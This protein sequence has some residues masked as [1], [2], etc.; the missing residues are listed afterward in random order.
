VGLQEIAREYRMGTPGREPPGYW[1]SGISP[2]RKLALG[3]VLF[4]R[5]LTIHT[6]PAITGYGKPRRPE[7]LDFCQIKTRETHY[8]GAQFARAEIR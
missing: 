8:M 7:G 3:A 2:A 5:E 1:R 4:L 6:Y